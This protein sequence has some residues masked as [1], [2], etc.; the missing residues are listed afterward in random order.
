MKHNYQII[1][2]DVSYKFY[3]I[4]A[5]MK[6][7]QDLVHYLNK[8]NNYPVIIDELSFKLFILRNSMIFFGFIGLFIHVFIII[9]I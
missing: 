2:F 1:I 4:Y 3:K 6:L 5:N 7:L 8:L 9:L